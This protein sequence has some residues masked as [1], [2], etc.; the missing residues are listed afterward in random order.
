MDNP[1]KMV[2]LGTQDTERRQKSNTICVG[3]HYAQT[4]TNNLN[5]T[6]ALLPTT[7]RKD[8]PNIA[9]M[10]KQ[11][12]TSQHGTQNVKTFD[13]TKCWISLYVNIQK[14]H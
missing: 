1:E 8:E 12:R 4:N 10:R 6:C 2:T 11:Q 14:T 5:K 7:G 9:L 13:R 3:H